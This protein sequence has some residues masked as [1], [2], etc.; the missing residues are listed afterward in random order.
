MQKIF[1]FTSEVPGVSKRRKNFAI[2]ILFPK[3][4]S[5]GILR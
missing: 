4:M 3:R 5:F 1:V 2:K